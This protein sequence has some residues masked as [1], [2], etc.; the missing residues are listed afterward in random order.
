MKS[1]IDENTADLL[2]A[3]GVFIAAAEAENFSIA[4]R[5]LGIT[6][7]GVSRAVRRLE[8][9]LGVQLFVRSTRI[10]KLTED[11]RLY[12]E[13]CADTVGQLREAGRVLGGRQSEPQGHLR[14]SVPTTYGHYRIV[15]LL[16]SFMELYPAITLD[17]SVSNRNADLIEEGFDAAIRMGDLPDSRLMTR[18]LEDATMGI[19]ASPSYLAKRERP[20]TIYDLADH[21]CIPFELPSTGKSLA[22][23]FRQDGRDVD[24]QPTGR[25]RFE[26]DVLACVTYSAGG[27][28]ICQIYRFIAD[29]HVKRGELVEL[30]SHFSGRSRPFSLI[31]PKNRQIS[32]K[33]R[34]FTDFVISA[35]KTS[36]VFPK[37]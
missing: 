7:A 4:A 10:V 34:V 5:N 3:I 1:I 29:A 25:A 27:G 17:I 9:R 35:C 6:P 20:E 22:W 8:D 2:P 16:S 31:Y 13:R 33:M 14:I 23:I 18:K 36:P 15:P 30:L 19:F 24:W 21:D 11:G 26:D 32:A 37:L 12:H 28:G